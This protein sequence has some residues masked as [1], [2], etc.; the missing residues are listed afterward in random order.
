MRKLWL[1]VILLCVLV[2]S[3]VSAY[4]LIQPKPA[5]PTPQQLAAI[6]YL[7]SHFNGHIGLVYESEDSGNQTINGANYSH[8]QIYYIYSDNL[9][10]TWALKPYEPQISKEIDQTIQSYNLP[11]SNFFEVLFGQ[12]ISTTIYDADVKVINQTQDI[13]VLAEFHNSSEPLLDTYG[14]TLI[15]QSL[16]NF[17]KGN[18]IAADS[19]FWQAYNLWDGKGINDDATKAD[20]FY[21]NYK[22]ALILYASK[23]LK[24]P[25]DNYKQIEENLW[26]MQKANGGIT[27]LADL[28][29]NPIGSANAETTALALLP[30]NHVLIS[31]IQSLFGS[32]A[33]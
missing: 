18:K 10:A 2:P 3:A 24:L 8:D 15:Y 5:Q 30:Y 4:I 16:N 12:P 1:A 7:K 31:K 11:H 14:N 21:A 28:N 29:G 22:L 25:I 19:Y 13:L 32:S 6:N 33:Y 9:L 17:L 27:S 26:S 23:V 20:H